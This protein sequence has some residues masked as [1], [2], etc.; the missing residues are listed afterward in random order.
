VPTAVARNHA[1]QGRLIAE[2]RTRLV[3]M[4]LATQ[5][6]LAEEPAMDLSDDDPDPQWTNVTVSWEGD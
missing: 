5:G 6:G 4:G 3:E 1:V 2:A